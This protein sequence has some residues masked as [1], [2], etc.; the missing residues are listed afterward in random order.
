LSIPNVVILEHR[1]YTRLGGDDSR[2]VLDLCN[3]ARQAVEVTKDGWRVVDGS[4]IKFRRSENA[5]A[6]PEPIAG[7]SIDEL[8]SFL[9]LKDDDDSTLILGWLLGACKPGGRFQS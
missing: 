5:L 9:S 1:V 4:P 2:I 6:L 8:R 3:S 7:G